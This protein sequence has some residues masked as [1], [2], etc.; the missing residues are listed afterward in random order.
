MSRGLALCGASPPY[1]GLFRT[2]CLRAQYCWRVRPKEVLCLTP[3]HALRPGRLGRYSRARY[4]FVY[5][6]CEVEKSNVSKVCF[7]FQAG[8]DYGMPEFVSMTPFKDSDSVC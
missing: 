2:T 4:L 3:Y 7:G 6:S 1:E 5:I 8:I